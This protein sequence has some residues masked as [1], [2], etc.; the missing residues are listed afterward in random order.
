MAYPLPLKDFVEAAGQDRFL[1]V[2]CADC[3]AVTFPAKS[4]CSQCASNNLSPIEIKAFGQ[5]RTF[6]VIRV[7]P[8]EFK[9]PYVVAMVELDD[10]PWVMGNL[11]GVDPDQAGMD[12]IG[13]KVQ[14]GSRQLDLKTYGA[15]QCRVLTFSLV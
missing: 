5:L 1:G 2:Q 15:D 14:M 9:P 12:L 10:G 4:T 11:E 13:R 3:R 8:L 6:T 7:A